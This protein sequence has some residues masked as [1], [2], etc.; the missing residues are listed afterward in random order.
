MFNLYLYIHS[1]T[2]SEIWV[3]ETLLFLLMAFEYQN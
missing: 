3:T 2:P 1:K